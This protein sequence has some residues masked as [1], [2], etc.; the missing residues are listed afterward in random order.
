MINLIQTYDHLNNDKIRYF[1]VIKS[2]YKSRSITE[3]RKIYEDFITEEA[4]K[5]TDDG[6][7]SEL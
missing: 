3:V 7:R 5:V 1:E 2:M 4:K 6:A